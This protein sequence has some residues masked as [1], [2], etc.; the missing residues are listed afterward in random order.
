MTMFRRKDDEDKKVVVLF[1]QRITKQSRFPLLEENKSNESLNILLSRKIMV[2]FFL[3][4][5]ISGFTKQVSK[6]LQI[7]CPYDWSGSNSKIPFQIILVRAE[8]IWCYCLTFQYWYEKSCAD[9]VFT[10]KAPQSKIRHIIEKIIPIRLTHF[11]PVVNK[12]IS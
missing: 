8:C 2:R 9:S 5:I 12:P 11:I 1:T 7:H 10:S 4:N 6:C 3:W